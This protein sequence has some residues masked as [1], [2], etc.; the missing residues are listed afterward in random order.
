MPDSP[1]PS[2]PPFV[3][4]KR[5]LAILSAGLGV[6]V[7][8]VALFIPDNTPASENQQIANWVFVGVLIAVGCWL[9]GGR[10]PHA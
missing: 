10:D 6:M 2:L 3:I 7:G 8:I 5:G 1:K 4:L 9:W